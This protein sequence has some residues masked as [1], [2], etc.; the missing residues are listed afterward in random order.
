[1]S[2]QLRTTQENGQGFTRHGKLISRGKATDIPEPRRTLDQKGCRYQP[3]ILLVPENGPLHL[4]GSDA[5]K[6]SRAGL[7]ALVCVFTALLPAG[8]NLQRRSMTV[9]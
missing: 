7:K 5:A 4:K 3:H 8:S 6:S 9:A 1:M 2:H